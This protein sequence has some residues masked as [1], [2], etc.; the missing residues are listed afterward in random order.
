MGRL[1]FQVGHVM[2]ASPSLPF[3]W[4]PLRRLSCQLRQACF[5]KEH[6]ARGGHLLPAML[7]VTGCYRLS[8]TSFLKVSVKV[9]PLPQIHASLPRFQDTR[10]K[11]Q[12]ASQCQLSFSAALSSLL[13][14]FFSPPLPCLHAAMPPPSRRVTS[15]RDAPLPPLD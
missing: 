1:D 12:A 2:R 11:I 4:M 9:P 14:L 15:F 8:H 3:H 6:K 10:H 5:H 7:S 13:R